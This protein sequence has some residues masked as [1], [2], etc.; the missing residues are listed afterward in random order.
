[1]VGLFFDVAASRGSTG[2]GPAPLSFRQILDWQ[3]LRRVDLAQWQINL[4]LRADR[5]YLAK[6][7]ELADKDAH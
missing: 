1:M 6:Y 7:H 2:F 3:D 4:V 5:A